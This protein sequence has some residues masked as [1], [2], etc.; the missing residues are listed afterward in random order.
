MNQSY[1]YI[2]IIIMDGGSSDKTLDIAKS[3]KDE[4]IIIVSENDRGIYDAWNK[5]V[6][7]SNGDW[8]TFIGSDDIYYHTNAIASLIKGIAVSNGAP[9]VYGRTAHEGPNRVISGFS[10]SEWYNLKGFKFNYYKCNLPL[11][12]MSAIYSRDFFRDE[13]FDIK[14]K[15]VADADWFL[16]CFIKLSNETPPYFIDDPTPVVRMGYGGVS[17]DISS[18]VKTTRESFIVRKKNNISCCNMQLILRYIKIMMMVSI[19]NTF[20]DNVFRAMHDGY[21]FLKRIKNKI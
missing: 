4:R 2:E 17:T 14:L 16:R 18:Q 8:I 19:K 7:L 21:H 15:I 6:D 10:G 1:K 9:V 20:G 11:P 13:R 5:A 12:I 3:F